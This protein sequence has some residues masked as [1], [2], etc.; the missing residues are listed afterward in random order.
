MSEKDRG[1]ALINCIV[2]TDCKLG[3]LCSNAH[4]KELR[5]LGANPRKVYC[6]MNMKKLVDGLHYT[7]FFKLNKS[8][9]IN[10]NFIDKIEKDQLI[11]NCHNLRYALA[12]GQKKEILEYLP[13]IRT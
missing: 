11:L 6:S 2:D 13:S 10:V 3:L 1:K 5:V 9:V 8:N 12:K 4:R 7:D